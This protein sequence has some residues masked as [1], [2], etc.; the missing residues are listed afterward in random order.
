MRFRGPAACC[1]LLV[2]CAT[3]RPDF[4]QRFE[5]AAM[6]GRPHDAWMVL[7]EMRYGC[8]TVFVKAH[9]PEWPPRVGLRPLTSGEPALRVQAGMSTCDLA[10]LVT[11]EVVRAW[12]TP[13]GLREEW[14]YR[15]TGGSP[16]SSVFLEGPSQQELRVKATAR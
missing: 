6:T 2:G 4:E 11:P 12:H 8:D 13:P 3:A 5:T 1:L 14:L 16:L 15:T 10:S 7:L 9:A